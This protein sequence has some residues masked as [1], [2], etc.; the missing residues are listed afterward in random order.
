MRTISDKEGSP[1]HGQGLIDANLSVH[2][3]PEDLK[4]VGELERDL[5]NLQRR[6]EGLATST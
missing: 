3:L 4:N 1:T 6:M 5:R 2:D